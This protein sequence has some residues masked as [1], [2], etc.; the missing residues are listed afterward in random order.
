MTHFTC[1]LTLV[2]SL[3]AF[4]ITPTLFATNGMNME[5]YGPVSTGLGGASQAVDHGTAALAQNPATL[6]LMDGRARFDVALGV[7]GPDVSSSMTGAPAADSGGTSYVMPA[8]GY[9]RRAGAFTYGFGVF[10]QGGMG[11]EYDGNSFLAAGSGQPVR[12]EL[13]VGRLLMRHRELIY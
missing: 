8:M 9:V 10:A 2:A 5:G 13:G 7:L 1:R 3:T 11:T 12:S 4:A 6:G